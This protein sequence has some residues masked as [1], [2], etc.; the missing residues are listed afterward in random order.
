MTEPMYSPNPRAETRR[1]TPTG[2]ALNVQIGPGDPISNVPVVMDFEHH[3]VHEG[4]T[5]RAQS[6]QTSLGTSTVKYGLTVPVV[7]TSIYGPHLVLA[8]DIYNGA[9]RIDMYADATF[10]G[11]SPITAYNRNRNV[12]GSP[13]MTVTGGVTS[14]NGTLIESFFAGA[15][16][17]TGEGSRPASEWVLK[18]NAIYRVDVSGLVANTQAIVGFNWYEDL[19]V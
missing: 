13:G 2:A 11:G 18:S 12:A 5:W 1:Q 16:K 9:A 14:T 3:Q 19:G 15:G 8:V 17:G 4:E 7:A 6:V 10:T